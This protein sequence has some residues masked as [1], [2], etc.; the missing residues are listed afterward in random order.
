M[1]LLFSIR[2]KTLRRSKTQSGLQEDGLPQDHFGIHCFRCSQLST[3][4]GLLRRR[5]SRGVKWVLSCR[6][7]RVNDEKPE[8]WLQTSASFA[9][10]FSCATGFHHWVHA[11]RCRL[12]RPA[13]IFNVG[14]D[15]FLVTDDRAGVVY[16]AYKNR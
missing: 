6:T 3:R 10:Y 9:W 8:S 2:P 14:P 15:S 4:F 13:D 5:W 11:G 16:Y 1:A 7:A 12:G